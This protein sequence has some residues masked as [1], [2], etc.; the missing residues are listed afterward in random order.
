L[1][2]LES[3]LDAFA[4]IRAHRLRTFLQTLGVILGVGSLVAVQGLTD[5][6]RRRSMAYF[7]EVG[8]LTKILI[9]NRPPREIN[10]S[11][12][13]RASNGLTLRDAEAIRAEIPHVT[14]IDPIVEAR[15]KVRRGSYQRRRRIAGVTPDYPSVY[16]F[17]IERGRFLTWEDLAT[18]ARTC[19]LGDSAAK[20]YFGNEDPVGKTIFLD[21]VGFTV[22]GVM[23]RKEFYFDEGDNNALEW[24][25]RQ[26][27][28]PLSAVHA[29]FTGDPYRKVAYINVMVDEI[30]NNEAT[31]KAIHGLLHYRHGGVTD[32]EVINRKDQMERRQEQGQIFDIT[33]LVTGIVSLIVGGIVIMNIMLASYQERIREIGIRKAVGAGGLHI[34]IQFLVES[35]LATSLGGAAGLLVG[36]GFAKAITALIKMPAEITFNMAVVSITSSVAV[37]IFFG[38]YPAIRAARLNPVE[39]LR[40]E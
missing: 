10:V 9:V 17:Y 21:D 16:K 11:A 20:D 31:A 4:D 15:L 12:Q 25:N 26:T 23:E 29:R 34:A 1:T 30:E 19:V 7:S 27:F 2:L 24:M 37:G 6:G 18:S 32:Y 8:G 39:A 22:V 3:L 38:L 13:Q 35:V 14:Q 40:Y 33:F 5:A 28:I 36:M